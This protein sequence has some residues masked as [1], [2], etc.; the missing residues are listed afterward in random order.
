MGFADTKQ[1]PM[2]ALQR[3]NRCRH[4]T[5]D[6]VISHYEMKFSEAENRL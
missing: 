6:R 4:S 2:F 3:P 1:T 5:D